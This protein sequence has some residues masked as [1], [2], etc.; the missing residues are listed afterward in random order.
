MKLFT[1]KFKLTFALLL[2]AAFCVISQVGVFAGD[3]V[4][5]GERLTADPAPFIQNGRTLVPLRFI[6]EN[7]GAEVEYDDTDRLVTVS[8]GDVLIKLELDSDTALVN[9]NAVVLDAPAQISEGRT[10]VPLRFIAEAF[11]CTVNYESESKLVF[12]SDKSFEKEYITLDDIPEYS[13]SPYIELYYNM[14]LFENISQT[15]YENYAPLDE[16]G[17]CGAAEACLSTELMPTEKRGSIGSVK[18]SGWRISK[19]DFID[20]Q[21]LFNRCHLI[22][23]MLAAENDNP[24][25]L[26]TGTRYMNTEGM[27]PF[28]TEVCDYIKKTQNH[29]MYRVT[30]VYSGDEPIARGV[31]MEAYSAEDNGKG[32][33]FDIFAY[34][35]QPCV[36]IDYENGENYLDDFNVFTTVEETTEQT[37]EFKAEKTT[38]ISVYETNEQTTNIEELIECFSVTP[39]SP[40]ESFD[41]ILNINTMK[42]HYPSCKSVKD[43]SDKNKRGYNGDA[44]QLEEA[45]F[46]PC[47]SCRPKSREERK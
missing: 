15:A 34:N 41:Y 33:C 2:A 1:E 42:F 36:R 21:Y 31:L 3:I 30:P 4:I 26:I 28:E 25:N 22:A 13:G 17:R 7:L 23:F 46:K 47:G 37:T 11:D 32:I 29:V 40:A 10:M 8:D 9:D 16:L 39:E 38:E 19:Y 6:S 45:G 24:L 12:I 20:G 35:V 43:I 5:N 27:L 18:P 44:E 14:P